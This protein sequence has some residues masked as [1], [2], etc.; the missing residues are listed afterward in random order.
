MKFLIVDDEADVREIVQIALENEDGHECIHAEDG[1]DAINKLQ[2]QPFD[3]I[4]CDQ[5][6]PKKNGTDVFKFILDHKIEIKFVFCSTDLVTQHEIFKINPPFFSI[7]KPGIFD[8]IQS[9][10]KKISTQHSVPVDLNDIQPISIALLKNLNTLAVD[11]YIKLAEGRLVKIFKE[12]DIFSTDDYEKYKAKSVEKL[13]IKKSDASNLIKNAELSLKMILENNNMSNSDKILSFQENITE[14]IRHYDL[15]PEIVD[16]TKKAINHFIK[17]LAKYDSIRDT[18]KEILDK[19]NSYLSVQA[20]IASHVGCTLAYHMKWNSEVTLYKITLAC[21]MANT[22]LAKLGLDDFQT[23]HQL[24]NNLS[25]S[26][27]NLA[28]FNHPVES[29]ELVRKHFG[30]VPPDIDRIVL[31]HHEKPDGT[32]FPRGLFHSNISSLGAI[33]VTAFELADYIYK[34]K[35]EGR[36][37]DNFEIIDFLKSKN[38]EKGQFKKL[39]EALTHIEF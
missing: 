7:A 16:L 33:V 32:G 5:R 30:L 24:E 23:V 1:E 34:L 36:K 21:F 13:W 9:L 38:Y 15:N 11:V 20:T 29:S 19:P 31:E 6:M 22:P 17:T 28:Y 10:L 3:V 35:E 2:N 18:L 37:P 12:G 14:L 39:L 4:I 25:K 8:G 27:K 26:S